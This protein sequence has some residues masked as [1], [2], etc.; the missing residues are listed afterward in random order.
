MEIQKYQFPNYV[1]NQNNVQEK[2]LDKIVKKM[3]EQFITFTKIIQNNKI[4]NLKSENPVFCESKTNVKIKSQN[5]IN[6]EHKFVGNVQKEQNRPFDD[7]LVGNKSQNN[8]QRGLYIKVISRDRSAQ[9]PSEFKTLEETINV[10]KQKK[11][12]NVFGNLI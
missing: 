9:K 12:A 2:I 6:G 8:N 3:P 11:H 1:K 7:V 4:N 5:Q 10:L